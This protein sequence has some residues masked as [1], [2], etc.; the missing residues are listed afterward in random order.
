MSKNESKYCKMQLILP[1]ILILSTNSYRINN[2]IYYVF[3][4]VSALQTDKDTIIIIYRPIMP[5]IICE[6]PLVLVPQVCLIVGLVD[7]KMLTF[8]RKCNFFP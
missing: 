7:E 2:N 8:G 6:R 5:P 3:G 1:A 4:L